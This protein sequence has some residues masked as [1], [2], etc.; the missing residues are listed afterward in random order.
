MK[1]RSILS[2]IHEYQWI[3]IIDQDG[4]RL[5]RHFRKEIPDSNIPDVEVTEIGA[6]GNGLIIEV[7]KCV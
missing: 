2:L 1:L 7:R 6:G 5:F 3:S 4:N